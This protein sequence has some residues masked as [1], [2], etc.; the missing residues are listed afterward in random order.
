M[1]DAASTLNRLENPKDPTLYQYQTLEM[2]VRDIFRDG[3]VSDKELTSLEKIDKDIY[4]EYRIALYMLSQ[5]DKSNP[6]YDKA[7]DLVQHLRKCHLMID[8]AT[9]KGRVVNKDEKS[10]AQMQQ[11]QDKAKKP[12]NLKLTAAG[13]QLVVS[14][15]MQSARID[16]DMAAAKTYVEKIK[17]LDPKMFDKYKGIVDKALNAMMTK[18]LDYQTESHAI[19]ISQLLG[20]GRSR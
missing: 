20:L 6:M 18:K 7:Y 1:A 8:Y 16:A 9:N 4:V 13:M 10:M 19:Q 17:V 12:L 11:T 3:E 2:I 15:A 5:M 14:L